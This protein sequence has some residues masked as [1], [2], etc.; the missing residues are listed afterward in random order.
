[1]DR[2]LSIF[3]CILSVFITIAVT[4]SRWKILN[5]RTKSG[6]DMSLKNYCESR[7][8]NVE[9]HNIRQ[10]EIVPQECMGFIGK[11]VSSTLY[12]VDTE[13]VVMEAIVYL[14]TSCN[15]KRWEM[16]MDFRH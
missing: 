11:Y 15:R 5:H 8:M 16:G 14:S 6:W 13:R 1:M 10:F 7:R 4:E 9:L 3:F 12:K 2:N